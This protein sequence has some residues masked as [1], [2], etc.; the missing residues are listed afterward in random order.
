M[1]TQ[2]ANARTEQ[3]RLEA[4]ARRAR[5]SAHNQQLHLMR[6]TMSA[7][8]VPTLDPCPITRP[9]ASATTHA[10]ADPTFPDMCMH[11]AIVH[12][13]NHPVRQQ[14]DGLVEKMEESVGKKVV[15]GTCQLLL[16]MSDTHRC[17]GAEPSKWRAGQ[18]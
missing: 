13:L 5:D 18:R 6:Q 8:K 14:S 16:G 7:I 12:P 3:E 4:E 17:G 10:S 11:P 2:L 1:C 9:H 15:K